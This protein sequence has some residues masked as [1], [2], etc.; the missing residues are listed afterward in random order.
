[1]FSRL[2]PIHLAFFAIFWQGLGAWA[3]WQGNPFARLPVEDAAM[4]WDWAN[5]IADGHLVGETPFLS[6]PLYPYFLGFL[7]TLGF[8]LP[9]ILAAQSLLHGAT[10]FLIAD[11]AR[12]HFNLKCGLLSGLFYLFCSEPT[13]YAARLLNPSVQLFTIA[14]VLWLAE[15]QRRRSLAASLGLSCLANPAMLLTIPFFAW[16]SAPQVKSRLRFA[17][18]ALLVISPATLHNYV[19]TS[20][21]TSGAE[22]ISISAQAG[23]TYFHGNAE[24]ATGIY[25]AIPGVSASRLQQNADAFSMAS[26]ATGEASWSATSN[27]FFAQGLTF[28]MDKPVDALLLHGRK[29]A[30]LMTSVHYGDVYQPTLESRNDDFGSP[31]AE[32]RTPIRTANAI[33]LALPA[34]FL[35]WRKRRDRDAHQAK[36]ILLLFLMPVLVVLI[37]WYGPRYRMPILPIAVFLIPWGLQRLT[38]HNRYWLWLALFVSVFLPSLNPADSPNDF[39]GQ[40]QHSLGA[41]YRVLADGAVVGT[42]TENTTPLQEPQILL[43][44]AEKNLRQAIFRGYDTATTH[45]DLAQTLM[46]LER[47]PEAIDELRATLGLDPQH[48]LAARNLQAIQEWLQ[49]NPQ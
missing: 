21:T 40:F 11:A 47:W 39:R 32:L 7:R 25:H 33:W 17:A 23:V 9:G 43:A 20:R 22:F 42:P 19:A 31:L 8:G 18:I 29:L 24:G 4:Y 1:M 10:V 16:W 15:Q 26:K 34:I 13:F 5:D 35:L 28:L 30:W 48:A 44:L 41:S 37:F 45:F 2:R 36:G 6:A 38:E 49:Q 12:R 3:A 27:Y 14:L 46:K